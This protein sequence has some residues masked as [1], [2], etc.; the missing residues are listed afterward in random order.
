M[1][2]LIEQMNTPQQAQTK[3]NALPVHPAFSSGSFKDTL[4][5]NKQIHWG[6]KIPPHW[7]RKTAH[8]KTTLNHTSLYKTRPWQAT[9][10]PLPTVPGKKCFIGDQNM[11]TLSGFTPA[12]EIITLA[13]TLLSE[14]GHVPWTLYLQGC[15]RQIYRRQW[16]NCSCVNSCL[17]AGSPQTQ[18]SSAYTRRWGHH[19]ADW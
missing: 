7:S 14:M 2:R 3:R 6:R 4:K 10:V 18:I 15:P 17:Q 13:V 1:Q 9:S 8:G 12:M 5:E 11:E 16:F 19:L